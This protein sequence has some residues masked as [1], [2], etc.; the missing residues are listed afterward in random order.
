MT[1]I[2]FNRPVVTGKELER[3]RELI[4]TGVFSG[5][6]AFSKAVAKLIEKK[7]GSQ[8]AILT[9]SCTD[10]LEM[11]ALLLGIKP[12]DEVI[13]PSYTFVSTA[14][15]FALRGA[16]IVWCDIREDTKNIDESKVEALVT[17][18]TKALV[19]VHYGGVGC[20]MDALQEICRRK[21]IR[22]VEDA[23]QAFDCAYRGKPLGSL[24]D[25]ATF[26]FH[27]TK[28]IHCGEGGALLVNN[29]NLVEVAE[30]VR[31]KGTDRTRFLK[32]MVDKYTWVALGSS[33]LMSNIQAAF[34]LPQLER[35]F[36]INAKRRILLDAYQRG[37]STLPGTRLQT[38]PGHCVPNGHLFYVQCDSLEERE[39]LTDFLGE[40][41]ISAYFHY[42]PL[43]KAPFWKG[44]YRSL[45]LP[46]TDRASD[47][48]LRMP[49]F[50]D[51]TLMEVERVCNAVR[52]FFE[53]RG[54]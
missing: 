31:D 24:G 26:S 36:E 25:L 45:S 30:I 16:E 47:G 2:P 51:L 21:K 28:N 27:D 17:D 46:V 14:S 41:G 11:C 19:A 9:S 50:Y 34:L 29:P 48:V 4:E 6:G 5:D 13:M 54:G 20:E 23:A 33:F 52:D 10:A 18:N 7:V 43:H 22:L 1:T 32:G 42:V 15:A 12:G 44:K 3:I 49:M 8:K 35:S 53:E 39:A 40:R 37:L 38:V